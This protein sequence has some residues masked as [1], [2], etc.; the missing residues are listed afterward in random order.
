MAVSLLGVF[1]LSLLQLLFLLAFIFYIDLNKCLSFYVY[2]SSSSSSFFFL[3]L[4]FPL[5]LFF[6][7]LFPQ[8]F[9]C[10]I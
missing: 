2:L 3:F 9:V 6:I 10:C 5:L 1:H 4:L 8:Y 7:A